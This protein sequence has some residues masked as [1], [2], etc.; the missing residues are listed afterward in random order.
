VS[1]SLE[2]DYQSDL[3]TSYVSSDAD[4]LI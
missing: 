1:A 4:A 2:T 3:P